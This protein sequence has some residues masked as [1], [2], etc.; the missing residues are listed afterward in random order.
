MGPLFPRVLYRC[1][2]VSFRIEVLPGPPFPN[3][4]PTGCHLDEIVRIHLPVMLR[5][6]HTTFDLRNEI[7][8]QLS[9]ANQEYVAVTELY[10][11][12]VMI[13]LSDFPQHTTIPVDLTRGATLPRFPANETSRVLVDL[14]V[15]EESSFFSEITRVTGRIRHLPSVRNVT[16]KIDE[17]HFTAATLWREQSEAGISPFCI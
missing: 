2:A 13:G 1:N 4:S 3:H 7:L 11:V 6:R 9:Q 15:I 10:A 8:R 5:A 14:S 17:V 12:M 16:L